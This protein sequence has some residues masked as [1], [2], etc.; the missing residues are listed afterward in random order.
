MGRN[1]KVS[2]R[3]MTPVYSLEDVY[4]YL[5]EEQ[6]ARCVYGDLKGFELYYHE[7][8]LHVEEPDGTSYELIK[9]KDDLF[10]YGDTE[11]IIEDE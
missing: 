2:I 11:W 9:N 7:G 4:C 6:I 8:K 3:E 1:N 5:E 10:N